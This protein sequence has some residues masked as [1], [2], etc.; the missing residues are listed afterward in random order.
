MTRPLLIQPMTRSEP[1]EIRPGRWVATFRDGKGGGG[2]VWGQSAAEVAEKMDGLGYCEDCGIDCGVR[3]R[4]DDAAIETLRAMLLEHAAGQASAV[5]ETR[6]D[7]WSSSE[8]TTDLE[9][10]ACI[11]IALALLL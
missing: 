10:G 9:H 11:A 6:V 8:D 2:V 1:I 7:P 4:D 3:D 5:R